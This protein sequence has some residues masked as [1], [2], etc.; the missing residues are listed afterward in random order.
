[1]LERNRRTRI[2]HC[3]N[4]LKEFMVIELNMDESCAS[5]LE[6]ADILEMAVNYLRASLE[7]QG[8]VVTTD[9]GSKKMK[10]CNSHDG[11]A[12]SSSSAVASTST[13]A[14][15]SF[16]PNIPQHPPL[17]SFLKTKPKPKISKSLNAPTEPM[18]R[19]W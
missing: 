2:S 13:N 7:Q 4:Q 1:M 6:K 18:W 12:S 16:D 5:R 17:L 10:N 3:I 8:L 15:V 19:P 11:Q 14:T 9:E